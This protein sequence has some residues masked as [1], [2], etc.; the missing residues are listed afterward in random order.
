MLR[1][2]STPTT[3]GTDNTS[4]SFVKRILFKGN[5]A[6][7]LPPKKHDSK[8]SSNQSSQATTRTVIHNGMIDNESGL[9]LGQREALIESGTDERGR[10]RRKH[11]FWTMTV[12]SAIFPF[13]IGIPIMM[14]KMDNFLSWYAG[15][16]VRCLTITQRNIIRNIFLFQ[17][18]LYTLAVSCIVAVFVKRG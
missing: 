7:F 1:Q 15:G 17:C 16:G 6:K 4:T 11:W 18:C 2:E 3:A 5:K 10:E 8:H 13:F 9:S 12:L 14:G